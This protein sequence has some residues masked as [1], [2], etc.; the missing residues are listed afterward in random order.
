ML[1]TVRT[2]PDIVFIIIVIPE[3]YHG[4]KLGSLVPRIRHRPSRI[5]DIESWMNRPMLSQF[6]VCGRR[7]EWPSGKI[8]APATSDELKVVGS[9]PG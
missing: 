8:S 1:H 5:M 3:N 6:N 9:R 7:S 2:A 4:F